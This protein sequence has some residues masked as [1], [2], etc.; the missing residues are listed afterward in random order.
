MFGT[1]KSKNDIFFLFKQRTKH[2]LDMAGNTYR[3]RGRAKFL[4]YVYACTL[5]A[6]SRFFSRQTTEIR[7]RF[8]AEKKENKKKKMERTGTA[9]SRVLSPWPE[10]CRRSVKGD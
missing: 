6:V 10:I 8:S 5:F 2:E 1:C 9:R 3:S 7:L 4:G